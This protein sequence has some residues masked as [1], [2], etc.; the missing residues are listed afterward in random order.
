MSDIE[1]SP[2]SSADESAVRCLYECSFPVEERRPW[3]GVMSLHDGDSRFTVYRILRDGVGIGMITV[4]RID[5]FRYVEHFAIDPLLRGCGVG[6]MAIKLLAGMDAAPLVL[7]VEPPVGEHGDDTR[8]RVRF[9]ENNGFFAFPEYKYVQPPYAPGLP[10]VELML[11]A[12]SPSVD[13]P[14]V[15]GALHRHVYGVGDCIDANFVC[16]GN[17]E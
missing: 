16:Y 9:Y 7:E 3:H 4:W 15:A 12:T 11:M 14:R 6:G 13:L 10:S 2:L 1:L 8:R 5:G 17:D